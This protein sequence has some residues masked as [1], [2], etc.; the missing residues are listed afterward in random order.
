MA[1][2]KNVFSKLIEGI[3]K[4]VSEAV[5]LSAKLLET[6]M[7]SNAD[8]VDHSLR[9]LAKLG[10]PYA[11]AH[12]KQI[13]DPN[14]TVHSQS[15]DLLRAIKTEITGEFSAKIGVDEHLAPHVADVVFGSNVMVSRDFIVGSLNESKVDI[16]V[17]I[18]NSIFKEI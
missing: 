15:G 18:K 2:N 4:N 13:H 12:P 7:K 3:Q 16:I 14:Y 17:T 9:E 8:E 11:V 5:K 1:T 6:K 10:H